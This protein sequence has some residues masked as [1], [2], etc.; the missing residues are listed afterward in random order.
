V[1][2]E[3]HE[4]HERKKPAVAKKAPSLVNTRLQPGDQARGLASRFNGLSAREKP[5]KRFFDSHPAFTGLKPGVNERRRVVLSG[6]RHGFIRATAPGVFA[7][8]RR[9]YFAKIHSWPNR[10]QTTCFGRRQ[11]FSALGVPDCLL[12]ELAS[13]GSD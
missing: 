10:Q 4:K 2:H 1:D 12:S 11:N 6:Q 5:L 7:L 13:T 9:L 8:A 3:I